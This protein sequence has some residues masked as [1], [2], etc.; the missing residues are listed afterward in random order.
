MA[1]Y[2]Y[3]SR[4]GQLDHH[5]F[6]YWKHTLPLFGILEKALALYLCQKFDR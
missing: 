4:Q 5:Y 3:V 1:M 6:L 2:C